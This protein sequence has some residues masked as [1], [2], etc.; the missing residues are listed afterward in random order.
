[1]IP[2]ETLRRLLP[3]RGVALYGDLIRMAVTATLVLVWLFFGGVYFRLCS[4]Q[5][6]DPM[7]T[8]FTIFYYS[9]R[10]VNDGYLVY[11]DLPDAYGF[12]WYSPRLENLNLPHVV[13]VLA[14]LGWF[15]YAQSSVLW[16]AVNL[17]SLALSIW[18][19]TRELSITWTWGRVL[20]WGALGL[21]SAGAGML[22]MTGELTLLLLLPLTLAWRAARRERWGTAG[23][24]LGL[25]MGAK[26]FLLLFVPCLAVTRR[27]RALGGAF[28]AAAAFVALGLLALGPSAYTDWLAGTRRVY[29]HAN[30]MNASLYGLA[31]RLLTW[32]GGFAALADAPWLVRPV[33]LAGGAAIAWAT[34]RAY[35]R[36]ERAGDV[37][38]V[39]LQF[40]IVLLGA[41]LLSPLG[42]IY[43]LPLAVTCGLAV[44]HRASLHELSRPRAWVWLAG[45]AAVYV[46]IEVTHVGAASPLL[47]ATLGSVYFW[48][49][50]LLWLALASSAPRRSAAPTAAYR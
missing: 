15:S 6:V 17:T 47:T 19:V 49:V 38:A 29:W 4:L 48:G 36:L 8:D 12:K 21:A 45:L 39:D 30:S 44:L 7:H 26:L 11:G 24:W 34:L 43:Y 33:W 1:M 20:T 31:E 9:A 2:D 41:L 22:A 37:G 23:A 25:A 42:W 40:L 14:P 3:A 10:M 16:G 13:L 35:R 28:A 32:Q 50:F 46:P 5:R 18:I 27:W